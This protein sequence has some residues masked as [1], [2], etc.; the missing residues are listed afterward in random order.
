MHPV[1]ITVQR[2]HTL[3]KLSATNSTQFE[4]P[5]MSICFKSG[6]KDLFN[7]V[8]L[9]AHLFGSFAGAKTLT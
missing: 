1:H 3:G 7:T 5:M 2:L 6:R 4:P 8:C 9:P